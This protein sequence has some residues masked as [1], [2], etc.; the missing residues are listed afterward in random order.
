M[1]QRS[2][3]VLGLQQTF[4]LPAPRFTE[5]ELGDLEGTV[6]T[7]PTILGRRLPDHVTILAYQDGDVTIAVD[8][9][10]SQSLQV[11]MPEL[12]CNSHTFYTAP[13]QHCT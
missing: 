9:R 7:V 4:F 11:V 10:R 6:R 2:S 8:T 1:G 12:V 3:L 13:M 5:K